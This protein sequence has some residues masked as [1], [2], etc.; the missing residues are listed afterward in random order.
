[1]LRVDLV[2]PVFEPHLLF[3]W[4]DWLVV[5]AGPVQ[6]QKLGLN[7]KREFT[8]LEVDESQPVLSTERGE[9]FFSNQDDCVLRRP[10]S[11]YNSWILSSYS[12]RILASCLFSGSNDR[13]Q[14]SKRYPAIGGVD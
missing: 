5:Q 11:A 10:T 13:G 12:E 7:G 2:N 8:F 1:M 4:S 3:R 6:A 14:F 9:I